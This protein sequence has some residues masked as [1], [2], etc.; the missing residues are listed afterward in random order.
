MKLKGIS[1]YKNVVLNLVINGLPSILLQVLYPKIFYY[2]F[3]P[4]YK[5]IT[6]NT[7]SRYI[8]SKEFYV[9]NL[10]INGLPS[11]LGWVFLNGQWLEEV[12]NLVINGLP[13]IP[14][15]II[16]L[17]NF[18]FVLNLVING[19][20]SIRK[21]IIKSVCLENLSFKPCYKWITFNTLL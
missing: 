12:L 1:D 15:L 18:S 17:L 16:L 13:S 8:Y 3:K 20:P 9:L 21:L 14:N 10:V 19:L 4:C 7:D 2:R 11:I 6:F 5:W